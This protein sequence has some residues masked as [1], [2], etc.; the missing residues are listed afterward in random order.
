LGLKVKKNILKDLNFHFNVGLCMNFPYCLTAPIEKLYNGKRMILKIY[1]LDKK[2][3]VPKYMSGD[4]SGIDLHASLDQPVD[5]RKGDYKCI[6]TGIVISLPHGYEAQVRPRSGLAAKYGVTVLNTPGTVDSDYR[7]EIKVILVNHGSHPFKVTD[8]MRIAQMVISKVEK[9][10]IIEV[11]KQ[12][13]ID[14]TKRNSDGF[15]HT[16]A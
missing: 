4:A 16:G 15:G 2:N 13:E 10:E 7:G 6:P 12:E 5:L 9:A 14:I 8:G 11:S 3:P 1:R